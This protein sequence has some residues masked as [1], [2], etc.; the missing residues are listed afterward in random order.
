MT[1]GTRGRLL[2][3]VAKWAGVAAL[4]STLADPKAVS[5]TNH[6]R[7]LMRVA[8]F[9]QLLTEPGDLPCALSRVHVRSTVRESRGTTV[10]Q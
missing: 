7:L 1:N 8:R 5:P 9:L 3:G 6:P 4:G 10:H 2:S